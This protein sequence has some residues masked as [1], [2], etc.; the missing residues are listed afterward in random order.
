MYNNKSLKKK[1]KK[2][3]FNFVIQEKVFLILSNSAEIGYISI[4]DIHQNVDFSF[5]RGS[6]EPTRLKKSTH[7]ATET[8]VGVAI[9]H[10]SIDGQSV[11]ALVRVRSTFEQPRESYHQHRSLQI[12]V[13]EYT[14]GSR[15]EIGSPLSDRICRLQ[16][17]KL[18]PDRILRRE[19]TRTESG[20]T[21]ESHGP[22]GMSGR[23]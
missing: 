8:R 21:V 20:R 4:V 12:V 16:S 23:Y 10:E 1:K 5:L 7:A 22:V 11:R 19:P 15:Q 2:I 3:L 18:F 6:V 14:Y 17:E 9:K 13:E